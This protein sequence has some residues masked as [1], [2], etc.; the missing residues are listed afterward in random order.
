M[1][2]NDELV[3]KKLRRWEKYINNYTLPAWDDIPDFGVYMEQVIVLLNQYLSYI[4]EA[5][6]E[7]QFITPPTINNYVRK[8]VMPEPRKKMYYR[9]HIAYLIII[10]TL[11]QSLSLSLISKIIPSDLPVSEVKKIYDEYVERHR[12][13]AAYFTKQ[14]IGL[15]AYLLDTDKT[16]IDPDDESLKKPEELII[17]SAITSCF[18]RLLA[19]KLLLL[20]NKTLSDFADQ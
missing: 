2:Y 4:P 8:N 11:K 18:S 15:S 9:E 1:S 19:E 16:N 14:I 3:A 5:L 13:A 12:K 7:E 6:K 17:T 20:D 10:I